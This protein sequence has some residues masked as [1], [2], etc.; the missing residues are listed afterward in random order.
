MTVRRPPG[1]VRRVPT[2]EQIAKYIELIN[3][4]VSRSYAGPA[5]GFAKEVA[6]A[7]VAEGEAEYAEGKDT[8]WA[9]IAMQVQAAEA[10]HAYRLLEH[11]HAAAK[12]NWIAAAW[13]LERRYG[14][15]RPPTHSVSVVTPELNTKAS[16]DDLLKRITEGDSAA[17]RKVDKAKPPANPSA[18]DKAIPM[19]G[20]D[21]LPDG[22][23]E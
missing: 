4:G 18:L 20:V 2:E 17:K 11:I 1:P 22:T 7:K 5:L 15:N 9:R 13:I 14:Y 21:I 12:K 19:L 8:V 6:L 3:G 10:M 23:D 16:V